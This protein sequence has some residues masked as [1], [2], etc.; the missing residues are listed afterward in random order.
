MHVKPV[1]RTVHAAHHNIHTL[2]EGDTYRDSAE[3]QYNIMYAVR[4]IRKVE[5]KASSVTKLE[6]VALSVTRRNLDELTRL[7]YIKQVIFKFLPSSL[8]NAI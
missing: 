4:E 8:K 3:V 7:E 1:S 2:R 6:N 5:K